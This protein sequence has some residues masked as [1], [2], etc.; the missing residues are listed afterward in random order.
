MF[1]WNETCTYNLEE[2][3]ASGEQIAA[4]I[5]HEMELMGDSDYQNIN[6]AGFGSG[7][8]MVYHVQLG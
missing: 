2:I 3:E 5:D 1:R 8:S 6:L 4:L 7:G